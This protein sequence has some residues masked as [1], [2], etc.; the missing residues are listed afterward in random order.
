MARLPIKE[1]QGATV[2]REANILA[3]LFTVAGKNGSGLKSLQ[4]PT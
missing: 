1:V 4:W 2:R 3:S